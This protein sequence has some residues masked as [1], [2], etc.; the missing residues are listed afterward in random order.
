MQDLATTSNV[1]GLFG[2]FQ[3]WR[4]IFKSFAELEE[5]VDPDKFVKVRNVYKACNDAAHM[6]FV[7]NHNAGHYIN[8]YTTKINPSLCNV[9]KRLLENV[10]RLMKEWQESAV[11]KESEDIAPNGKKHISDKLCS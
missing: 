2:I 3:N 8:S 11:A 5:P 9:L 7:D 1:S 4:Q 6:A 10:C